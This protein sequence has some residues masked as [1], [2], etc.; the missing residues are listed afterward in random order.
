MLGAP[1]PDLGFQ[2]S[3]VL[4]RFVSA[5]VAALLGLIMLF[6]VGFVQMPEIHDAAHDTRHGV[7]FPCH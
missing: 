4:D 1:V 2:F 3:K 5:G 6:G 7:G